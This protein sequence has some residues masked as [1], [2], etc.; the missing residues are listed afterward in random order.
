VL[1]LDDW[2]QVLG[3]P[4][5]EPRLLAAVRA[6]AGPQ[7]ERL[8]TPPVVPEGE[9]AGVPV[10]PFPRWLR[11]P[12][13]SLLSPIDHGVFQLRVDAWRPERTTY[14][15]EGCP[16][17]HGRRPPTAFPARYL[18]SCQDGHL[19]DFPW[20]EFIHGGVPC[21]GT[22]RLVEFGAGGRAGDVQLSCDEC[23]RRRRLSQAF[24]EEAAP[25][26]PPHCRGRHP[27]LGITEACEQKAVTLILGASNAWFA[28]Q[29]SALSIPSQAGELAQAVDEAWSI[30]D[31]IPPGRDFL[32]FT[33]KSNAHLKKLQALTESVGIDEV[34]QAPCERYVLLHSFAHALIRELALECGY[35]A[36]SIRER[37][38]AASDADADPMAGVLLYTAAPDS[39]GTLGGLVS[40]GEPEQFGP[41]LRQ[42]LERA[43]LCSSDPLCS[44]HD[45]RS[46]NSVHAAACHAC[47]FASET[48]CERGNRYLDRATIS[49]TLVR[50][51]VS[52]FAA[53]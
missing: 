47:Q 14:V 50:E 49:A 26:L 12:L 33:L 22:L 6:A 40:L 19:D 27:H 18:M 44:E 3:E 41:L 32:E 30:L 24:G 38:Y 7:V 13:C 29:S 39:E 23:G 31:G 37:I 45:P 48:S 10:A 17:G 28:V 46:D 9:S 5:S 1:G 25:F 43:Q 42:A 16:K 15:H 21:R 35:T 20:V 8:L 51:D 11:C 53:A 2:P 34:E 4:V 36:S 52:Y